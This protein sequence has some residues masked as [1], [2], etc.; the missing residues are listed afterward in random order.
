MLVQAGA[1]L[2][3]GLARITTLDM[4]LC[5]GLQVALSALALMAQQRG[6][7][8]WQSPARAPATRPALRP[9]Q[10]SVMLGA[11]MAVAVLSKGLVGILIPCAAAGLYLIWQWDWWIIIRARPWWSLAVLVVLTAP[12][13]LLVSAR[14]PEFA[15]FFFI[16]QHFQRFLST[17]GFDRY[18]PAWFF[19]PTLLL[20]CCRGARCCRARC[21][22]A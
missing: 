22:R 14:N 11:G 10:L 20:A 4:S 8:R 12:W 7:R 17:A 15:H 21:C 6:A 1:L 3:L 13:F 2:Y 16:V 9:W 19:V 18:Q 5:F